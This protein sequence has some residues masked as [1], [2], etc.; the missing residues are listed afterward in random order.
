MPRRRPTDEQ[1]LQRVVRLGLLLDTYGA[2]LTEKQGRFMRLH[3]EE[4]LSFGEIAQEAGVS[5]QAIHDA[6]KHAEHS[7]E[8]YE[9]RLGLLRAREESGGTGAPV[10]MGGGSSAE[11]ASILRD[12]AKRLRSAGVI[13]NS[14]WIAADLKRALGHLQGDAREEESA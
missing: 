8:R 2:L 9:E 12:L 6:V 1:H 10:A 5:R 3:Y 4:D 14:D 13:Y 11:A 7:L